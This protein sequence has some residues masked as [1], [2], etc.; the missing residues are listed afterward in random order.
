MQS[1]QER[2]A[3][4]YQLLRA[5]LSPPHAQVKAASCAGH[6]DGGYDPHAYSYFH[7]QSG[8][9]SEVDEG[10][11]PNNGTFGIILSAFPRR[12]TK[13]MAHLEPS[14]SYW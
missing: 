1:E 13:T 5:D 3:R 6:W 10:I 12:C 2:R 14:C 7:V 8:Q 11:K 9:L 4:C